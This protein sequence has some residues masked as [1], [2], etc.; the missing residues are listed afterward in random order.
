[1]EPSTLAAIR[2]L[3][4]QARFA[5]TSGETAQD[6]LEIEYLMKIM[7]LHDL[8]QQE[9]AY[10]RQAREAEVAA[11]I[12]RQKAEIEAQLDAQEASVGR[13]GLMSSAQSEYPESEYTV[14][15]D[16]ESRYLEVESES[17]PQPAHVINDPVSE[18]FAPRY[19]RRRSTVD[20]G[21]VVAS[22]PLQ[23]HASRYHQS[24]SIGARHSSL[25]EATGGVNAGKTSNTLDAARKASVSAGQGQSEAPF[26]RGSTSNRVG[27]LQPEVVTTPDGRRKKRVPVRTNVA[28]FSLAKGAAKRLTKNSAKR[29]SQAER[30]AGNAASPQGN[31]G[32]LDIPCTYLGEGWG[33]AVCQGVPR[34]LPLLGRRRVFRFGVI[35]PCLTIAFVFLRPPFYQATAS[36]APVWRSAEKRARVES[37]RFFN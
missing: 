3:S 7:E 24:A 33:R 5:E 10:V 17:E 2:K 27:P 34:R 32:G 15:T 16:T 9:Q 35:A 11:Y 37:E 13:P 6:M 1:M 20:T 29:A 18:G 23:R 8:E 30:E 31:A 36:A 12:A 21:V 14:Y 4:L 25:K 19:P 26:R 28:G 22:S